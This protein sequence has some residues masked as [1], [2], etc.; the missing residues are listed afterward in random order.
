VR[1]IIMK[2]G[3]PDRPGANK[4]ILRQL[5]DWFLGCAGGTLLGQD[6]QPCTLFVNKPVGRRVATGSTYRYCGLSAVVAGFL[7]GNPAKAIA[8][9]KCT[10]W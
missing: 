5:I 2:A 3:Q 4:A 1:Y 9:K 10:Q 8:E 6:C 7:P